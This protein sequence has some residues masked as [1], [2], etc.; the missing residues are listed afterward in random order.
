MLCLGPKKS[1]PP[2]RLELT[3]QGVVYQCSKVKCEDHS[4]IQAPYKRWMIKTKRNAGKGKI[5]G[6]KWRE[7]RR[8]KFRHNISP[9]EIAFHSITPSI[10]MLSIKQDNILLCPIPKRGQGVVIF[11]LR[12]SII[13]IMAWPFGF[14]G[15][16]TNPSSSA[17]FL[18]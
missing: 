10:A 17:I 14:N 8:H 16:N 5:W 1:L 3:A 2:P 12:Y 9:N 6:K 15:R 11:L 4:A 7:W 13:C 18:D